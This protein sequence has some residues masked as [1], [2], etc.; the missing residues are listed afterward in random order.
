MQVP[1]NIY[2]FRGESAESE[3]LKYNVGGIRISEAVFN[4]L[5]E[6]ISL[7][8][9]SPQFPRLWGSEENVFYT[10][11]VSVGSDIFRRIVVRVSR[12]PLVE[13]GEFIL[14]R[15]TEF[16]IYEVCTNP[17]VYS[18]IEIA[19]AVKKRS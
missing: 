6:E 18:A 13:T 4:R 14:K 2:E 16:P 15:W 5:R 19:G 10:G 8:K 9:C 3:P 7:D 1:F 11:L 12:V 17:A